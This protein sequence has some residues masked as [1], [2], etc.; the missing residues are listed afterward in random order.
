MLAL[1]SLVDFAARFVQRNT[2]IHEPRYQIR[3]VAG[4]LR[5]QQVQNCT[6][7]SSAGAPN[8]CS[9]LK[10]SGSWSMGSR[11]EGGM[12]DM[13]V[14]VTMRVL[15]SLSSWRALSSLSAGIFPPRAE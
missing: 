7:V 9:G 11:G 2:E 6:F 5:D 8:D 14:Y 4:R 3:L 10:S 13:A 1:P 12:S 15:D